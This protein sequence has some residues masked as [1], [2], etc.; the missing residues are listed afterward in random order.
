MA[1]ERHAMCESAFTAPVVKVNSRFVPFHITKAY[2]GIR[3]VVLLV[4]NLGTRYRSGPGSSV[5]IASDYRLDGPGARFSTHP[6]QLWGPPSLLENW[7]WVF[8]RGILFISMMHGHANI[9]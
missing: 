3:D 1:E 8:P 5:G 7:Y 4:L 6:D 2:G 9:R